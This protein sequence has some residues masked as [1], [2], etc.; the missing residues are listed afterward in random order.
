MS[1]WIQIDTMTDRMEVPGGWIVR[2]F[3]WDT[4][5]DQPAAVALVFVPGGSDWLPTPTGEKGPR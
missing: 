5:T 3:A 2:T 4:S 1:D